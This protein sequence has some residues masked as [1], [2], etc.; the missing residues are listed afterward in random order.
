M[1]W[2]CALRLAIG[3]IRSPALEEPRRSWMIFSRTR[4]K[5]AHLYVDFVVR[6]AVIIGDASTRRFAKF[7]KDVARRVKIEIP[8]A[9][10]FSRQ[11]ANDLRVERRVIGKRHR[12]ADVN[13][14]AFDVAGD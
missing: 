2:K 7:I 8:A 4:P 14:A 1:S 5:D 10:Q 12:V 11:I 13:D 6:D 3:M 9:A